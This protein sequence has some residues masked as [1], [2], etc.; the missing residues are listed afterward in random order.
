MGRRKT[1]NPYVTLAE[2]KAFRES[3]INRLESLDENYKKICKTLIGED[4]KSGLVKDVQDMR[5]EVKEIRN[6]QKWVATL[7][8]VLIAVATA[9]AT[10][11]ALKLLGF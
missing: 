10:A 2:C 3:V 5:S 7:K 4:M 9:L 1:E 6:S 11:G 8:G